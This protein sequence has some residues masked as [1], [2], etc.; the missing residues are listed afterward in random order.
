[1]LREGDQTEPLVSLRV[2]VDTGAQTSVIGPGPAADLS[3]PFDPD[4][5]VSVCGVGGLI[6]NIPGF[7]IDYVKIGAQGGALEFSQAP[8]VVL[9]LPSPELGSLDGILGMNFFWN[10]NVIFEPALGASASLHVSDP[11]TVA[12]SDAD[13]DLDI[14]LSD[15]AALI[16][17]ITGPVPGA[18][19]PICTQMDG[20]DDDDVDMT[21]FAGMQRCFSGSGTAPGANCGG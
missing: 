11:I 13:V 15:A 1:H 8:F 16:S 12:Y 10:R 6:D 18:V 20:D 7:Y 21:D 17:C 14:D 3:L 19:N 9:D 5:T 4:F 2:L